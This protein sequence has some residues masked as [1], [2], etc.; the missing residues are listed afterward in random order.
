[1]AIKKITKMKL[2]K[3]DLEQ[4]KSI[5]SE[6]EE[7]E[8]H[9]VIIGSN[10]LTKNAS[11]VDRIKWAICREIIAFKHIT[12]LTSSSIAE[13]IKLDK[14]RTSEIMHYRVSQFTIDRLLGCLLLL[15]GKSVSI[16]QRIEDI[17]SVFLVQS[18]AV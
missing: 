5:L 12:N 10:R 3:N 9:G 2:S 16:D 13:M 1:M 7:R 8:I 11:E 15:K 4:Y 6:I 18:K 17:L 14:S